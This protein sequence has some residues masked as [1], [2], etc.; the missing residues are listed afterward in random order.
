MTTPTTS[1]VAYRLLRNQPIPYALSWLQWVAFH[2]APVPDLA[3]RWSVSTDGRDFAFHLVPQA[4]WHDGRPVTAAD[5]KFTFE[6]VL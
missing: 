2:L 1:R 6:E 3:K 5:V 4:T